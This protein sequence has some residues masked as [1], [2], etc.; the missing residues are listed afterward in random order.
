MPGLLI[1]VRSAAEAGIATAGGCDVLDVKDPSAGSLGQPAL[2][3]LAE[4]LETVDQSQASILTSCA[5]G[6]LINWAPDPAAMSTLN[7]LSYL[8]IGPAGLRQFDDWA[9]RFATLQQQLRQT[10]VDQPRW[11]AAFYLD[12]GAAASFDPFAELTEMRLHEQLCDRLGCAG[13]LL[14]TF[15]KQGPS[16]AGLILNSERTQTLRDLFKTARELSLMTAF[17]GRL[18]FE[19][20]LTLQAARIQP[21]LF[22]VRS[23]V[24]Q[25]NQRQA[26]IDALRV[27]QLTE[28]LGRTE[29]TYPAKTPVGQ[30]SN[31]E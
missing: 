25:A 29:E 21:D 17:A 12:Y 7:R 16:A 9:D 31:A 5:L 1:S 13:I 22:A 30:A 11:I 15:D 2:N 4:I 10:G 8:K 28:L 6:E 23:A 20:V 14:D 26:E 27:Q 19:D 18:S 24:C 3:T